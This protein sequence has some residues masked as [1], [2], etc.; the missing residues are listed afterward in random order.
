MALFLKSLGHEAVIISPD[1]GELSKRSRECGLSTIDV[2]WNKSYYFNPIFL[3]SIFLKLRKAKLDVIIF[4]SFIDIRDA[5]LVAFLVGINKRILRVGMPIVPKEKLSYRFA[6]QIGLT[7]FVGISE[8][9]NHK[10]KNSTFINFN[11]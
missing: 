6:F 1:G 10:F 8:E 3:V 11:E 4:N 9:I 5:S 7:E 2:S